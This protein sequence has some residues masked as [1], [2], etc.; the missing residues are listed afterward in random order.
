MAGPRITPILPPILSDPIT[1]MG[2][3]GTRTINKIRST[4]S[5][6]LNSIPIGAIIIL[7]S[8]MTRIFTISTIRAKGEVGIKASMAAR[9]LEPPVLAAIPAGL[10]V[11]AARL[12][13]PL[14]PAGTPVELP[15]LAARPLEPLVLVA[16]RVELLVPARP[17]GPLVPAATL[18]EQAVRRFA[19]LGA[20]VRR[21]AALELLVRRCVRL[22][23][24]V[25]PFMPLELRARGRAAREP[26]VLAA[27]N[28]QKLLR[29]RK[30]SSSSSSFNDAS[31]QIAPPGRSGNFLLSASRLAGDFKPGR[32]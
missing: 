11:L 18:L 27:A 1:G 13:E 10:L 32:K 15:V 5:V 4:C 29:L 25:L 3:T 17:L 30:N 22:G 21:G 19:P 6:L 31:S 12:L 14:V 9:P 26:L 7:V 2:R 24:L 28:R 20:K 23:L 8:A 16:I